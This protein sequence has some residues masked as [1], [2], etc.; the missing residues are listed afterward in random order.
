MDD[1][2]IAKLI[3]EMC[4]YPSEEG[5]GEFAVKLFFERLVLRKDQGSYSDTEMEGLIYQYMQ[6]M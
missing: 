4:Y 6:K 3:A 5:S 2:K 1:K